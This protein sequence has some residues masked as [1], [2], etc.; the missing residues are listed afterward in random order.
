[1]R[2]GNWKAR[3]P[4]IVGPVEVA[5][6]GFLVHDWQ[7]AQRAT[8]RPVKMTLPGPMTIADTLADEYYGEGRRLGVD[9]AQA[10]NVEL[11]LL[12]EAGCRWIQV[13]EPIFAVYPDSALEFGIDNLERCLHGLDGAVTKVVHICCGYPAQ[14]DLE[15]Y[16][17]ADPAAYYDLAG[18]L[19]DSSIDAVSIEDAHRHNDLALLERFQSTTVIL[20]VLAIARTR[21]ETVD[22]IA[23]RLLDALGHIDRARLIAA[24]DCGLG[25]L[26]RSTIRKKLA[27]MVTAARQVAASSPI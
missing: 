11:R 14:V 26:G 21:V 23:D 22:Q 4:T 10:I 25:M 12:A 1:M 8:G 19:D 3:V 5:E 13:D 9:L 2:G 17:K 16:P 7:V 20:G 6:R 18:S 27:N 24:P 15:D